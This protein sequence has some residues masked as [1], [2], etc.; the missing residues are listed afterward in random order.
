M[1]Q[2]DPQ[3]HVDQ[4]TGLVSVGLEPGQVD[5]ELA[6]LAAV[7]ETWSQYL[8]A[9]VLLQFLDLVDGVH[10]NLDS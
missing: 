9:L 6:L 4:V 1:L 10:H 3:G 8:T 5:T 7:L 2:H